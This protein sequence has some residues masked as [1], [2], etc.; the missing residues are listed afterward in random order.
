MDFFDQMRIFKKFFP[1][2]NFDKVVIKLKNKLIEQKK[3][4]KK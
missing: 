2:N 3:Q 4:L 1:H